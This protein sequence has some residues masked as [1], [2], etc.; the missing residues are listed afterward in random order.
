MASDKGRLPGA[1]VPLLQGLE[2]TQATGVV[3]AV[4]GS[5]RKQIV[6]ERGTVVFAVSGDP[7]D[8]I[9]QALLRARLIT[10]ND[11]IEALT[12]SRTTPD[13]PGLPRLAAALTAMRRVTPEECKIVFESKFRESVLDVFLWESG[14]VAFEEGGLEGGVSFP[15]QIPL[16]GL[17]EDGE[18]R[19]ARWAQV[20]RVLPDGE[21]AF[22]RTGEWGADFPR[23]AGD[24]RLAQL[25]EKTLTLGQIIAELRG[26]EYAVSVRLAMLVQSGVL[27]T[28][29]AAG[30]VPVEI[31][32]DVDLSGLDDAGP[33]SVTEVPSGEFT[34]AGKL[35]VRAPPPPAEEPA[36][37]DPALLL[38]I[39]RER[40]GEGKLDEAHVLLMECIA[41]DPMAAM[42]GWEILQQV[43]Q[44]LTDRARGS[45]LT[46][47]LTLGLARPITMQI[48]KTMDPSEAFVM[49]RFAAGAMTIGSLL[50]V[51]PFQPHEVLQIL[52]KRV[53]DG[54][55][56]RR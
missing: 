47:D 39:A 27:R 53:A 35:P 28:V 41:A 36:P 1:W 29:R 21:I 5:V 12:V 37:P 13:A 40:F 49:S 17:I 24:Q 11:L 46:D 38:E 32:V 18:K 2:S 34:K 10:E 22:E 50:A 45:G 7:R 16:A 43:E 51:C 56:A 42:E 23:S 20:K 19:R 14:A 30:F 4:R 54:T 44:G 55:L 52:E 3:T 48:G 31:E 6:V 26:Q 33:R 9:G 25:V 15:M 8:L